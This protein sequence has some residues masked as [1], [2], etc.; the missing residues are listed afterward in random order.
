MYDVGSFNSVL[1]IMPVK[2]KELELTS[3]E[4]KRNIPKR[5]FVLSTVLIFGEKRL[6]VIYDCECASSV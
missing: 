6:R 2:K 4:E 1:E 3:Q 5:F